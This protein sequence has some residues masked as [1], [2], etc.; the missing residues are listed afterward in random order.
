MLT[1][2]GDVHGKYKNYHEIIQKKDCYPYTVQLGDFGFN[3]EILKDVDPQ[4]HKIVAGNHDNYDQIINFPH[5][6]GDYGL[7]KLGDVEFF[8]YRGAYSIDHK[9][10][11]IGIDWWQNEQLSIDEFN[12]AME[13]YAN[14]KP[15]IV[16]TH[17]CPS[18]MV[19]TML[20]PDQR[21]YQNMT[22]WALNELLHIHQPD[23]WIHGHYHV[24]KKTTYGKTKFICLNELEI[25]K[26]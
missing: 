5:Y 20:R 15:N 17:D 14:I 26:I 24:S 16:I 10:R 6:L 18:S 12:K 7:F 19:T 21:V 22:G 23:I 25:Y 11:T 2:I 8:F 13:L 1:I 3:Y 9:T 4:C